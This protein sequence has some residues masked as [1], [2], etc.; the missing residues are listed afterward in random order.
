MPV[1]ALNRSSALG[2]VYA[3][4]EKHQN[5]L[6]VTLALITLAAMFGGLHAHL[7]QMTSSPLFVVYGGAL[8]LAIGAASYFAHRK[9]ASTEG[10]GLITFL[11]IAALTLCLADPSGLGISTHLNLFGFGLGAGLLTLLAVHAIKTAFAK[12]KSKETQ[13]PVELSTFKPLSPL[14]LSEITEVASKIKDW[15][16]CPVES[17]RDVSV[18]YLPGNSAPVLF[19]KTPYLAGD[20]LRAPQEEF[21]YLI[22]QR[23]ELNCVPTTVF[24][25]EGTTPFVLQQAVTLSKAPM[26]HDNASTTSVQQALFLNI[27][28]G[29]RD[30]HTLN[31]VVDNQNNLNEIDNESIGFTTTDSWIFEAYGTTLIDQTLIDKLSKFSGADLEAVRLE[32]STRHPGVTV[33]TENISSNFENLLIQLNSATYLR[34]SDLRNFYAAQI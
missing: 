1:S 22:S 11:A 23:L 4:A 6:I 30:A 8:T 14:K 27:I 9:I 19:R 10:K 2:S 28:V 13:E 18:G 12:K 31:S 26:A 7:G 32:F 3:F 5:K 20:R 24:V 33:N 17:T 21:V 16:E 15:R 25:N 34:I 29:R